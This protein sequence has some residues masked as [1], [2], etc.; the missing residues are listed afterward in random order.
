M[1]LA[2]D[3]AD[4]HAQTDE[5]AADRF[6][7]GFGGA[8]GNG[9]E[10]PARRFDLVLHAPFDFGA[11]AILPAQFQ[12]SAA[13]L[14][15][16]RQQAVAALAFARQFAQFFLKREEPA[17]VFLPQHRA[18]A[19]RPRAALR[20]RRCG[21]ARTGRSEA[22]AVNGRSPFVLDPHPR[23]AEREQLL[24]AA[25]AGQNAAAQAAFPEDEDRGGRDEDK[26]A[27][28]QPG[29]PLDEI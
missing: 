29:G 22:G 14:V 20:P 9:R 10:N 6:A 16:L 27:A 12:Q 19:Q 1:A 11:E 5:G 23:R 3:G 13:D 2:L 18:A 4:Q 15:A 17:H 25:V 26:M 7:F 8:F 21:R 24:V 28:R